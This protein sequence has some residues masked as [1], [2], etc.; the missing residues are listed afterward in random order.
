ML[1]Q[2]IILNNSK[3]YNFVYKATV[4]SYSNLLTIHQHSL[5][6]N[7]PNNQYAPKSVN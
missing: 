1:Q 6:L 7:S 2:L 4:F 5:I 3:T